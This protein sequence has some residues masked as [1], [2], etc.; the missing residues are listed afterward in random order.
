MDL[1]NRQP[2]APRQE[3]TSAPEVPRPTLGNSY[4]IRRLRVFIQVVRYPTLTEACQ[5]HDINPATLT[6]QLKRLEDDLGGPLLIRA[7]RGRQL[8]LTALGQ[9][10]VQAGGRWAHTLADQPRETWFRASVPRRYKKKHNPE[11]TDSPSSCNLPCEQSTAAAGSCG[12][13]RLRTIPLSRRTAAPWA[14]HRPR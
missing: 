13:C 2:R 5:T 6:T 1:H 7:G 3:F 12:S 10:V 11:W 14:P 4:A 9:E 8:E